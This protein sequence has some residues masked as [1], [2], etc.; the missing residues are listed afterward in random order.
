MRNHTDIIEPSRVDEIALATG[1]SAH[2]VRSWRQRGSIP[3]E[4]W[5]RLADMGVATLKE[6][7]SSAPVR[8]SSP[9]AD[10]QA[11]A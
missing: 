5:A 7:A 1:K 10:E 8:K 11:A 9:P 4:C 6:L 2:T 3:A